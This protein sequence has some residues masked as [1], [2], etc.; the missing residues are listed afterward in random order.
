MKLTIAIA[1]V[2]LTLFCSRA[3]TEV[4]PTLLNILE[5]LFVG[6]PSSY[7]ATLEPFSSDKDMK[8]A[9]FQLKTLVDTLPKEAK[10]SIMKLM[11]KVVKSPQCA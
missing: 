4:C 9:V 10:A 11:D 7:Q 8:D 2:T 6:T 1:L 3:S 5:N